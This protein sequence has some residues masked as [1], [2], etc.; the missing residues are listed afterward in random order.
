MRAD[1]RK[2]LSRPRCG[3]PGVPGPYTVERPQDREDYQDGDRSLTMRWKDMPYSDVKEPHP[4]ADTDL[5]AVE[6][7]RPIKRLR[8]DRTVRQMAAEIVDD[9]DKSASTP[10]ADIAKRIVSPAKVKVV[11]RDE[12]EDGIELGDGENL[13]LP[14]KY[15][16][17]SRALGGPPWASR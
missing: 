3:A 1:P 2:N 8:P 12:A 7:D 5:D 4:N 13:K 9:P 10:V 14:G 15:H 16:A 17:A 6:T 11:T